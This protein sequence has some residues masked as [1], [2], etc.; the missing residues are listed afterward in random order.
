VATFE[1]AH[2]RPSLQAWKAPTIALELL[3]FHDLRHDHSQNNQDYGCA[4]KSGKTAIDT[5]I[6]GDLVLIGLVAERDPTLPAA[7]NAGSTVFRDS[8]PIAPSTS[9]LSHKS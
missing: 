3:P 2:V 1:K 8:R 6:S 4:T 5:T 9:S 7:G